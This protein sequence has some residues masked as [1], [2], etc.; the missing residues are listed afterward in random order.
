[1]G[2]I[3]KFLVGVVGAL[4]QVPALVTDVSDKLQVLIA[5]LT[6][7]GVFMIPNKKE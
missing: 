7:A 4:A 3:A 5:A 2:K 1:M 6:A